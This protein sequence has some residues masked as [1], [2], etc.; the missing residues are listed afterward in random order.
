MAR[1]QSFFVL[2]SSKVNLENTNKATKSHTIHN[3]IFHPN[4]FRSKGNLGCTYERF[5]CQKVPFGHIHFNDIAI[6]WSGDKWTSLITVWRG[7]DKCESKFWE[8]ES[9]FSFIINIGICAYFTF[10]DIC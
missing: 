8:K 9:V 7:T 1:K 3:L 4:N 6:D 5:I 2:T 10:I